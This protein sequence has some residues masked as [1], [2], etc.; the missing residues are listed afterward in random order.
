MPS[1]DSNCLSDGRRRLRQPGG[2]NNGL[3]LRSMATWGGNGDLLLT[4]E[5]KSHF[6]SPPDGRTDGRGAIFGYP[7]A[8]ARCAT[9]DGSVNTTPEGKG[10]GPLGRSFTPCDILYAARARIP[11][12]MNS[13]LAQNFPQKLLENGFFNEILFLDG[14][15]DW[16]CRREPHFPF[17]P[18][19]QTRDRSK[20]QPEIATVI[21]E[22]GGRA[23]RR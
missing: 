10:S 19:W 5:G 21:D 3:S 4:N 18:N 12:K 17:P 7:G 8:G 11:A 6:H 2:K 22:A 20:Q 14:D 13:D 9:G 1:F 16:H 23:D 15:D